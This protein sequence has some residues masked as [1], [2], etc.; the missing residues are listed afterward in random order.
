MV[1]YDGRASTKKG[2]IIVHTSYV[3][4]LLA[5]IYYLLSSAPFF[6]YYIWRSP[7]RTSGLLL[8]FATSAT[9]FFVAGILYLLI[10][11]STNTA[12]GG[13]LLFLAAIYYFYYY[14]IA[15]YLPLSL[16]GL[17]IFYLSS[18]L[19]LRLKNKLAS[20]IVYKILILAGLLG[21]YGAFCAVS[22]LDSM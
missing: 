16:L 19:I 14:F 12:S 4:I 15:L 9:T 17:F 18:N 2:I 1:W 8:G 20:P 11:T 6:I 22:I 13:D 21:W 7:S 10:Y 5:I 3:N